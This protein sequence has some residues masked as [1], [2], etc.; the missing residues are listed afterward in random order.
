M[1]RREETAELPGWCPANQLGQEK[2]HHNQ[3]A[4]SLQDS[5]FPHLG[6]PVLTNVGGD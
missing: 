4:A 5:P 3:L 6:A 1:S 2:E